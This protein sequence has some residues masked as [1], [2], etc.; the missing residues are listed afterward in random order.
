ME[1][2]VQH[3][4]PPKAPALG[5]PPLKPRSSV[6][7]Y[8]GRSASSEMELKIEVFEAAVRAN[9][10]STRPSRTSERS[11]P[12]YLVPFPF[13]NTSSRMPPRPTKI[14]DIYALIST[15]KLC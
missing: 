1:S 2:G 8:E 15:L 14:W 12:S 11:P 7:T 4:D 9:P 13:S 6:S 10:R 5:T 3:L